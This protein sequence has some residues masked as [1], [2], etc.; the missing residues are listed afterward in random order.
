MK[1]LTSNIVFQEVRKILGSISGFKF[2][3]YSSNSLEVEDL[4][5]E[6]KVAYILRNDEIN[7]E[8]I[9]KNSSV[10]FYDE[11]LSKEDE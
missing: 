11:N 9:F 10:V 6:N 8:F 5:S 4:K 2:D 1:A 3:L 7:E